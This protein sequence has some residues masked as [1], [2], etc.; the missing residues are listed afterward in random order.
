VRREI[1]APRVQ[2]G[3]LKIES[4]AIHSGLLNGRKLPHQPQLSSPGLTG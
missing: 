4:A 1:A 3:C 2:F